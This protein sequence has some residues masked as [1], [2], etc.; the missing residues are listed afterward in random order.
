MLPLLIT[1]QLLAKEEKGL[2]PQ[3][4]PAP[5]SLYQPLGSGPCC[6]HHKTPSYLTLQV[7]S[8]NAA[9]TLELCPDSPRLRRGTWS[10]KLPLIVLSDAMLPGQRNSTVNDLV[11]PSSSCPSLSPAS[12]WVGRRLLQLPLCHAALSL[13]DTRVLLV[14]GSQWLPLPRSCLPRSCSGSMLWA[15]F[16]RVLHRCITCFQLTL[17][18]V[19]E[20]W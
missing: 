11:L 17:D 8:L 12:P 16:A 4:V 7:H 20:V 15:S 5:G 3:T 2:V 14:G 1:L 18:D 10:R 6:P 19:R 13:Q 9:C